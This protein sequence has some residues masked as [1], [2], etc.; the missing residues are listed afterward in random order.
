MRLLEGLEK[1]NFIWRLVMWKQKV[2]NQKGSRGF[3]APDTS[4][5]LLP[6]EPKS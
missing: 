3:P 1:Q 2:E 6:L 4:V 5:E